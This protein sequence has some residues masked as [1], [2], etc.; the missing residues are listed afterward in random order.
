MPT[1]NYK[2]ENCEHGFEVIQKISDESLSFCP[3]CSKPTLKR[4]VY[5]VSTIFKGSGWVDKENNR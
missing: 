4:V 2:C 5:P 3:D 1:Y